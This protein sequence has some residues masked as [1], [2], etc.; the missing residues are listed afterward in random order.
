MAK[1]HTRK[2][3]YF[4]NKR[5]F[6]AFKKRAIPQGENVILTWMSTGFPLLLLI[7]SNYLCFIHLSLWY[8]S[9]RLTLFFHITQQYKINLE[10]MILNKY[11]SVN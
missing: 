1:V 4:E 2:D 9:L 10:D 8:E 3:N 6:I 11:Q 7:S 5:I